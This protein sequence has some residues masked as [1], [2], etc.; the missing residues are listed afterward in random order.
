MSSSCRDKPSPQ[1]PRGHACPC[2]P[3]SRA[4]AAAGLGAGC[5]RP[6]AAPGPRPL[7]P[8]LGPGTHDRSRGV[9]K[10]QNPQGHSLL[11]GNLA[12][13]TT[14]ASLEMEPV[15]AGLPSSSQRC[16]Q[17]GTRPH[18]PAGTRQHHVRHCEIRRLH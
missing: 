9:R 5:S 15:C 3:G 11:L 12:A 16:P 14:T 4:G 17:D 13:E 10:L 2:P 1:S 7:L 8:A 6:R 18:R